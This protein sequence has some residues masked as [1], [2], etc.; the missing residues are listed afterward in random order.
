[1]STGEIL[2]F[3]PLPTRV[4]NAV[5]SKQSVHEFLILLEGD[6]HA[7]GGAVKDSCLEDRPQL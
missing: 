3:S 1:M 7:L 2:I 6:S 4:E 5:C